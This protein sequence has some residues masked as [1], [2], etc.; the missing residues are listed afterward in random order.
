MRA[1]ELHAVGLGALRLLR[2]LQSQHRQLRQVV[3]LVDVVYGF[4]HLLLVV[5]LL[6]RVA[7]MF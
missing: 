7:V 3:R 5:F 6:R 1:V 2:Y 4:S